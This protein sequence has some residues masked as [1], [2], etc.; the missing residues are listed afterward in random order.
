M[1]PSHRRQ[2]LGFVLAVL[3]VHGVGSWA[4]TSQ[5]AAHHRVRVSDAEF[6]GSTAP[7]DVLFVGDSHPRSAVEPRLL[8]PGVLNLAISGEHVLKTLYRLRWLLDHHDRH[9]GAV[10]LAVESHT[11][12]DWK[13]D[14]YQ[15]EAVWG[16]YV[17]FLA[18]GRRRGAL[19]PYIGRW[20]KSRWVPYAGELDTIEQA[21]VGGRGF[22]DRSQLQA[23]PIREDRRQP[24]A[25]AKKHF[26]ERQLMHPD[27]RW[28]F[29]ALVA[30]L[31]RREIAVVLVSYP[32]S[33]PYAELAETYGARGAVRDQVLPDLVAAG[34]PW[35]DLEGSFFGRPDAWYDADHMSKSGRLEFTRDLGW[36][37]AD[38]GLLEPP[39]GRTRP[40]R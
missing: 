33:K 1:T 12:V 10:V 15:P 40:K 24:D 14:A 8:G 38:L 37:L 5:V 35:L 16:R 7:I 27:L 36:E 2:L 20:M 19:F 34:V 25:A 21:W 22:R 11:F 9:V 18:L 13:V 17:D 3:V 32:V 4:Y 28:A 26:A 30:D 23:A 29:D 6:L 31:Q 39:G